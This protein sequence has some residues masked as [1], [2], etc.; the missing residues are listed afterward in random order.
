MDALTLR[1]SGVMVMVRFLYHWHIRALAGRERVT[2]V[3]LEGTIIPGDCH[4][5]PLNPL[6]FTSIIK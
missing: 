2:S 4:A 3:C 1:L 5:V 6:D